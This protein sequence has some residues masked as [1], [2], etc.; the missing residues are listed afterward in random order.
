MIRCEG[1]DVAV[2]RERYSSPLWVTKTKIK[3]LTC[4][5]RSDSD[6]DVDEDY[7]DDAAFETQDKDLKPRRK[8]YE[9]NAG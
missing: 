7:Q 1:F 6:L 8:A 2:L 3:S 5:S 4:V 9:G